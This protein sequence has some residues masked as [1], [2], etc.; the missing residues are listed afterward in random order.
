MKFRYKVCATAILALSSFA[1][2]A[3]DMRIGLQED[4]DVLDPHRGPYLHGAHRH[5]VAM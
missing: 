4:V 5:D 1:A 3:Q 2:L